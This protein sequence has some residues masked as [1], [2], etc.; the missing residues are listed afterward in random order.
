[1]KRGQC[2]HSGNGGVLGAQHGP[3]SVEIGGQRDGLGRTA[4][5]DAGGR[6]HEDDLAGLE[7]AIY[8]TAPDQGRT[9]LV[10]SNLLHV[11]GPMTTTLC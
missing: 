11:P 4:R 1:M 10:L 6:V 7:Y 9:L 2:G 8:A 3:D 5:A